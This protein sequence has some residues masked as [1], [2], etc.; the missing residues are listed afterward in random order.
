M[1]IDA[2]LGITD[3]VEALHGRIAHTPT[4]LGGPI[5]L[6][7]RKATGHVYRAVRGVTR[8][9]GGGLDALLGQLAPLV[10]DVPDTPSRE[11]LVAALNGVLGDYLARTANPL[12]IAMRMRRDGVPLDLERDA[13]AARVTPT[14]PRWRSWPPRATSSPS[15]GWPV[16]AWIASPSAPPS[17]SG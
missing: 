8:A 13:L 15:T 5:G 17:T 3:L 10:A 11:A 2:T 12:A 9:V 14:A 7:V 6:A 4:Q 16:R 1:A